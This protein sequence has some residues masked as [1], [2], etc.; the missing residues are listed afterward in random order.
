MAERTLVTFLQQD[1]PIEEYGRALFAVARSV[2]RALLDQLG[3]DELHDLN[4]NRVDVTM[5]QLGRVIRL[6]RDTGMRGDGFEW[7]VHE[8]IIGQEPT[9]LGHLSDAMGK[10][11]PTLKDGTPTSLLFGYERA[12]Y[13][14]FLDAVVENAGDSALLLPDGSGRPFA[15]GN[16]VRIAARGK[17]AEAELAERIRQVWKTDLFLSVDRVGLDG[18]R[19]YAAATIKSNWRQLEDGKGLRV[20]IVPEAKDLRPGYQRWRG[21]HLAVLPDPNGFMGLFNDGYQAV[22]RA[23]C[24]LGKQE[25]PAYWTKPSAK[26][27]R[28]QAM[29]EKFGLSR[30]LGVE[31]ALNEAAQQDLVSSNHRLLSVEAP[32][33]LHMTERAV[34]IVAPKP[35]FEKLD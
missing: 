29:L 18:S 24:T 9:V 4:C 7:A 20:G 1:E 13:L 28:L 19:R 14:G 35:R 32:E 6:T 15:F 33:W 21:L 12:R 2:L 23:L 30:V 26:A 10:A 34:R 3:P 16:W 22:G 11:S 25:P 5:R 17:E 27:Q 8:A 31:D